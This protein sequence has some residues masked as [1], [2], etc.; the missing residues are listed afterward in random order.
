VSDK[1]SKSAVQVHIQMRDCKT[2]YLSV[3]FCHITQNWRGRPL[4]SRE[5]VVNLIGHT[6][7]VE[8]LKIQAKLDDNLYEAGI[9]VSD[10]ELA[11]VTI[12]RDAFH[13][14]WNYKIMP[15]TPCN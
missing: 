10:Q 5:V 2:W 13:G 12:E 14:E 1:E 6:T 15:R 3:M 11:E 7:T 4:L 8:G 9:K